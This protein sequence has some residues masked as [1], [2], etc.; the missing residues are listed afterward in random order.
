[1]R[2]KLAAARGLPF[3]RRSQCIGVDGD[4]QQIALPRKVLRRRSRKLRGRREMYEAVAPVGLR[5]GVNSRLLG[6][7]PGWPP[8]DF[9]DRRHDRLFWMRCDLRCKAPDKCGGKLAQ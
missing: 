3:E 7:A 4:Q 5:A 9:V 8:T 6:H 1:M 2:K